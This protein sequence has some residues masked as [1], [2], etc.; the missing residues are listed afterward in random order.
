MNQVGSVGMIAALAF[1]FY[2]LVAGALGGKLRSARITRSA[3]RATLAFFGMVL[4]AVLALEYLILTDDFHSS[5]VAAHSNRALPIYYKIPVLWSGQEGSLLFWTLLLS[6]YSALVVLMNRR[7]N[8]QLMPYVVSILMGTGVFFS[9][10]ILFVANPF[11]ELAAGSAGAMRAFAP[12]DG[13]G[14]TPAL[15]YP[16]MVIHPP[17]LYLGYVGMVV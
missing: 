8:R 6:V 16:S 11:S 3:E 4:M 14:L 7:R 12:P 10:L 5:Y 17:M 9:S 1:S 15:Q 13:N 2:A